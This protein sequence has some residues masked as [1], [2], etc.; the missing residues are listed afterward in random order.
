M[1]IV[2]RWAV[3]KVA[4]WFFHENYVALPMEHLKEAT[5]EGGRVSAEYRWWRVASAPE[6]RLRD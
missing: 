1:R 4:Q 5:S 3:A 6:N 2:P